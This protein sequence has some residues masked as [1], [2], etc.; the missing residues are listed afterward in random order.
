MWCSNANIGFDDIIRTLAYRIPVNSCYSRNPVG[1]IFWKKTTRWPQSCIFQIETAVC[2]HSFGFALESHSLDRS[3]QLPLRLPK[4]LLVG[5]FNSLQGRFKVRFYIGLL[6]S[7]AKLCSNSIIEIAALYWF[8]FTCAIQ[9]AVSF[10][11][12]PSK[13]QFVGIGLHGTDLD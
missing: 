1:S 4:A 2:C 12:L 7:Q 10:S 3:F 13:L 5:K 11:K 9:R 8:N 6:C